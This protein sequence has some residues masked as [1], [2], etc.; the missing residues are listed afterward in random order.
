[1]ENRDVSGSEL[2]KTHWVQKSFSKPFDTPGHGP[3]KPPPRRGNTDA[4][5]ATA[6]RI[7]TEY[8]LFDIVDIWKG[9]AVGGG[10]LAAVD[11]VS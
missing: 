4:N 8:R 10:L 7:G 11:C 3:Y 9:Y 5:A 6:T 1:M 2:K